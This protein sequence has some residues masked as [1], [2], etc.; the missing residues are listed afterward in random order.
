MGVLDNNQPNVPQVPVSERAA[1]RLRN[2][3]RQ[4]YQQMVSSF[5]QGSSIFWNNPMGATPQEV[6]DA[7]GGDAKE[8]FEL[9]AKLGALLATVNPEAIQQ[10][11]SIVGNFTMNQNGTITINS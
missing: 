7:L 1:N 8:I 3:T 10:G 9:H 6:A 5:N 4:T 11:T 2:L